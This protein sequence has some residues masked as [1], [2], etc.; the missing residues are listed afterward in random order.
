M[1]YRRFAEADEKIADGWSAQPVTADQWTLGRNIGRGEAGSFHAASDKGCRAACKPAF[2]GNGTPRAAHERIASD[3]ARA[4]HLPVPA[5][6]L[7]TNPASRELFALSAWAFAQALTW[8][9][10]ATRLSAVFMQNAAA[11]FSAARVFHTWIGDTDHNGNPGNVVV[12]LASSDSSP[13]IAFID[14]AFSMSYDAQFQTRPLTALPVS[15]IPPA[16][17]DAGAARDMATAINDLDSKL[18][19]D[20]VRRV[21]GP[22]LPLI[23][24]RSL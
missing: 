2:H 6:C 4:L 5:V 1:T 21:P 13:G 19:E 24:E 23:R 14:H 17:H 20:T 15:Y 3:L 22:F 9:E 8:G 7:W 11:T 18:I 10:I 16:L 12:D